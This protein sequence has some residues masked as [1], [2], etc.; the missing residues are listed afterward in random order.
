MAQK[1]SHVG[2]HLAK[3]LQFHIGGIADD[4]IKA[5][6]PEYFG[7]PRFPVKSIDALAF[8]LRI[9]AEVIDIVKPARNQAVAVI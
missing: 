6:I 5:A 7:K 4:K 8:L 3:I 9:D 2:M 1:F